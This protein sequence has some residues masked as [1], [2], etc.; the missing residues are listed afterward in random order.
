MKRR[1][2]AAACAA[3][4]LGFLT[5]FGSASAAERI[6]VVGDSITGHSMNLPYGFTHQVRNALSEGGKSDVEFIPLGGS[7]QTIFSWRD[8]IANSRANEQ[9][10]DIK[11][12]SVK[13]EFDK[14]ADT[15]LVHL[16]MN[17]ALRPSI[18]YSEEGL[19]SWKAE[20]LRLVDDL[21]A[22]VPSAK[23]LI[24]SPPT[25]LTENP[26]DFK[27]VLM[28]RFAEIVR[29]VAAERNAEFLDI[30]G[31]F[32]SHFENARLLD[33]TIR[34]TLDYVHPN[35][36]GHQVMT[37]SILRGI[38][39]TE[40][41]DKYYKEKVPAIA[42][43]QE[44]P[45][46]SLFLLDATEPDRLE[47][48]GRIRGVAKD[49]VKVLPPQGLKLDRI[50]NG[51]GDALTIFLTGHSTEWSSRIGVHAGDVKRSVRLSAPFFV[52]TGYKMPPYA[53]P[54]DFPRDKAVT[55]IDRAILD[56]K[57]PLDVKI[58][59][60]PT[61]W[62]VYYHTEDKTGNWNP[63]TVDLAALA[64][65]DAFDAAYVVR[66]VNS[67]KAQTATLK[68][69][70]QGFSTTAINTVYLNGKEVYFGCLSPRHIK[71]EDSV[72][73]E[74][75]EGENILAARVDHTYWQWAM[76]FELQAEGLTY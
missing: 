14:G 39:Q 10:L 64:P 27:N 29:E 24:L 4:V 40:I 47:I 13:S 72:A 35:E 60:K 57:N 53:K 49:A 32:R 5:L 15:L 23:K 6:I 65:A 51:E 2:F 61:E 12:I 21:R 55:P 68:L 37:W 42:R 46:L 66:R 62:F 25:L 43:D 71:L 44:T 26:Y 75:K 58:D 73:V 1:L 22:R 11:G 76:T 67:P 31:D 52:S 36:F 50:E 33:P 54:E 18:D 7:G 28:D 70:A 45:G 74:L 63:N 59:G 19:A 17:D 16:G 3:V 69:H 20:Y 41:A 9:T 34:I 48:R 30:R 56:G 8:I 38:G